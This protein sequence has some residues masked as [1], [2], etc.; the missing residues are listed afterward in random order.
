MSEDYPTSKEKRKRE[1]LE[2]E[3]EKVYTRRSLN[4]G[5]WL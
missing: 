4:I 5:V 3:K 2:K 1:G